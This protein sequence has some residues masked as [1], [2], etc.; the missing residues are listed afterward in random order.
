MDW[1]NN[2]DI[3]DLIFY[4][5]G[6]GTF[7]KNTAVLATGRIVD[8]LRNVAPL[9]FNN[10]GLVDFVLRRV[11]TPDGIVLLKGIRVLPAP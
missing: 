4:N 7:V 2:H 11:D 6:D 8:N 3:N 1:Q 5:N 9:D 10:D